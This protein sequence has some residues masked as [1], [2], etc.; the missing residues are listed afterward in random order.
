MVF[1]EAFVQPLLTPMPSRSSFALVGSCTLALISS[2]VSASAQRTV[3]YWNFDAGFAATTFATNPALDSSGSDYVIHG[4]DDIVGPSYSADTLTGK[5]LC[6]RL[7]APQDGY[8]TDPTF[9]YW[10]PKQWTIEVSVRLDSIDGWNTIIG[11]DG[12]SFP[13]VPKSDFYFQ[14]DGEANRFRLDFATADGARYLIES[15]FVAEA[16]VWYHVAL[17]SDGATVSMHIDRNDGKGYELASSIALDSQPGANKALATQGGLWTFGRGWY[18]GRFVDH[19]HGCLDDIRFTEGALPPSRFLHAPAAVEASIPAPA[20]P[21]AVEPVAPAPQSTV[22][23]GAASVST[24]APALTVAPAPE[25]S[26]PTSASAQELQAARS[27]RA[28]ML[29][30]T[31]PT[32]TLRRLV[33]YRNDRETAEGRTVV[34]LLRS[35]SR[36]KGYV[37]Q[38][39]RT[40]GAY[41]Y[42]LGAVGRN[43]QETIY[44]PIFSAPES[45]AQR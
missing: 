14:N 23:S 44:G 39:P 1:S 29:N 19:V 12:S 16:G 2:A 17:V 42:W 31:I 9:N 43:G 33:I 28:V 5:G 11:R 32:G 13:G 10:S 7:Y 30:W 26:A 20:T 37:D 6:A 24:P 22:A 25:A 34:G 18:D 38:L 8:T 3:A 21:M 4:F 45:A 35:P 41:W 40:D 15:P 36:V 27:G